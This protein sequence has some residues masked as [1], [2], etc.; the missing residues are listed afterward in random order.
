MLMRT[1]ATSYTSWINVL[2]VDAQLKGVYVGWYRI[3]IDEDGYSLCIDE[4]TGD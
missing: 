2:L 4:D 1:N 3:R